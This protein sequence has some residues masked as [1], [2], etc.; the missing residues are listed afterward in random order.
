MLMEMLLVFR[1][2]LVN[3]SMGARENYD[4]LMVLDYKKKLKKRKGDRKIY[5][6]KG[7]MIV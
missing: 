4:L 1:Y 6:L 5:P 7:S 3:Q 2:P